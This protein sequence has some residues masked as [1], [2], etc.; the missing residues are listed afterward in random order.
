MLLQFFFCFPWGS[1][2][3]QSFG[4]NFAFFREALALLGLKAGYGDGWA[5]NWPKV[6]GTALGFEPRTSCMRVRSASHYATGAA[7]ML[8]Q[9]FDV[10]FLKKIFLK[11]LIHLFHV[12]KAA[13]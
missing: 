1:P 6:G 10:F 13:Y 8:L 2:E 9:Y 7:P 3:P 12:G 5:P 11:K 4:P